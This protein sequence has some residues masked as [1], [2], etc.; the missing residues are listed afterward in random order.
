M[1][2]TARI[3][4][5]F[6]LARQFSVKNSYM[7]FHKSCIDGRTRKKGG[8]GVFHIRRSFL[9]HKKRLK[10]FLLDQ[11]VPDTEHSVSKPNN[12]YRSYMYIDIHVQCLSF[13]SD[14]K[15]NW[16]PQIN[17]SAIPHTKFHEKLS[18]GSRPYTC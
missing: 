3:F 1:T 6:M 14:F 10:W 12:G 15:Q 4:T 11:H 18:D 9:F 13:F 2:A 8:G 5:K 17:F 7:E 16:T